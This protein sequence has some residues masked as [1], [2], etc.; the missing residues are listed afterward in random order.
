MAMQPKLLVQRAPGYSFGS[1]AFRMAIKYVM[2]ILM[3]FSTVKLSFS[4]VKQFFR[5]KDHY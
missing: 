3:S 2:G 1:A 4:T 5:R